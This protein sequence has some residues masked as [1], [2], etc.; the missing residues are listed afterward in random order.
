MNS[1]LINYSQHPKKDLNKSPY[2]DQTIPQHESLYPIG[3]ESA[4]IKIPHRGKRFFK[5]DE[6]ECNYCKAVFVVVKISFRKIIVVGPTMRDFNS[7]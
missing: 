7:C 1:L 6:F 2:P 5:K 3:L 4:R